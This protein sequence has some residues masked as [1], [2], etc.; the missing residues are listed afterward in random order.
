LTKSKSGEIQYVVFKLGAETF[1]LAINEVKE[2]IVYQETTKIPGSSPFVDGIINLRGHVIPVFNIRKKFG[3]P[4]VKRTAGTRIVV[5]EA[6]DNIVGIEVDSVSEVVMIPGAILDKPS[7]MIASGVSEDYIEGIA[8]L[9]ERL[10]IILCLQNVIEVN[11][12]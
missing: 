2:I 5:V 6:N 7:S 1:G 8:K 9:D 4:P 11:V 12:A 10:I 3:L